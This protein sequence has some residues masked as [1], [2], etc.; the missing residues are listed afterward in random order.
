MAHT[1]RLA[2]AAAQGAVAAMAMT[3]IRD[4]ASSLGLVEET[5]PEAV[6][7]HGASTVTEMVPPPKRPAAVELAH[8]AFGATMAVLFALLPAR[9]RRHVW[10]GP[11]FG[12][13]VWV[14]FESGIGPLL[15]LPRI[16]HTRV[17]ERAVLLADH[18]VYGAMIGHQ[19]RAR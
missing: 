4:M 13:V 11:L 7:H 10:A 17:A 18:L 14:A 6:M 16:R 2:R 1:R 9:F 8:W 5:P 12:A 19:E 3:G 15:G